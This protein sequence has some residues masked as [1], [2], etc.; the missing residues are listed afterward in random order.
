MGLLLVLESCAG[1]IG[2]KL[3]VSRQLCHPG[4]KKSPHLVARHQ[5]Q[6]PNVGVDSEASQMALEPP[7]KHKMSFTLR[8]GL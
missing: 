4:H 7:L 8:L 3:I 2:G 5:S 1:F 6:A